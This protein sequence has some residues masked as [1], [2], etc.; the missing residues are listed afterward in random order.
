MEAPNLAVRYGRRRESDSITGEDH[1]ETDR[2]SRVEQ[3]VTFINTKARRL[4]WYTSNFGNRF[5]RADP[6]RA[7]DGFSLPR[8][9]S[10]L[11][12]TQGFFFMSTGLAHEIALFS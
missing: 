10:Q 7:G 5:E 4:E 9:E 2:V 11:Q 8:L 1:I 12:G 3:R 6:D